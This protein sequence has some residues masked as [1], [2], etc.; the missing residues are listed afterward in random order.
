MFSNVAFR[1][2]LVAVCFAYKFANMVCERMLALIRR[3]C[4]GD[5]VDVERLCSTG[6]LAQVLSFHLARDGEDPRFTTRQQLLEDGVPLRCAPVKL[7]KPAPPRGSYVN[8]MMKEEAARA[9]DG[10]QLNKAQYRWWQ[11][12]KAEEFQALQEDEKAFH[13]QEAKTVAAAKPQQ[14][15]DYVAE[16]ELR[17]EAADK[18]KLRMCMDEVGNKRSPLSP[19]AFKACVRQKLGFDQNGPFPG[20]TR[21]EPDFRSQQ[22]QGL[23]CKEQ[24]S[25]GH[26][27]VFDYTLPC[28]VAHP[29]AVQANACMVHGSIESLCQIFA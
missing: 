29:R 23:F 19:A 27:E 6:F 14:E 11:K 22:K 10:I 20:F 24:S 9:R 13:L 5:D 25:I 3:A 12:R 7:D 16:A 15:A 8:W 1:D 17:D 21:Y 2:L 18:F 4:R 26:E 28:P